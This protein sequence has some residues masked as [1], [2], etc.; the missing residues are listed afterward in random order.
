M[1]AEGGDPHVSRE[2]A[3]RCREINVRLTA[4]YGPPEP[5]R[6]SDPLAGLIGTI[7][8][9]H[10][11]DA[12]SERA[13]AA[14]LAR[15]GDLEAVS[16]APV[17]AIE[18]AI[19]IGGL[20]KVKAPRIKA[21]LQRLQEERGTLDLE[22]LRELDLPTARDYLTRL[23]GVGPKTAACVLLFNLGLPA[24]P[25]DTHV[26]RV[27][28]R[29]GLIGPRTGAARAHAILEA[30]VPPE[31]AYSFHVNLIRHGRRVCR[32]P[33]AR[34]EIC[35]LADLCPKIGVAMLGSVAG[36][37]SGTRAPSPGAGD[38]SPRVLARGGA[39]AGGFASPAAPT[40]EA[41]PRASGLEADGR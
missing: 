28:R 34:C 11:S 6:P 29:L 12:N 32:A 33:R 17:A 39:L 31:K 13:F 20:A 41:A 7:L 27:S 30:L 18:D 3:A 21:V 10:T 38:R 8:S 4:A 15:F 1:M 16:R 24:I 19:R 14:L 25:V 23:G 5:L 9:Q 2:T 26:H 22:F 36:P 40:M 35:P 37:A